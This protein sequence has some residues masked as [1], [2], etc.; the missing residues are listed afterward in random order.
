VWCGALDKCNEI[1]VIPV[2]NWKKQK[3]VDL[4]SELD[5]NFGGYKHFISSTL[6]FGRGIVPFCPHLP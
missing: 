4:K 5:Q 6:T 3:I 2:I 1:A